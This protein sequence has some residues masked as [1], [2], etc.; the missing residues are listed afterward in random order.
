MR[1]RVKNHRY[2]GT[3]KLKKQQ[4]VGGSDIS[5]RLKEKLKTREE[6]KCAGTCLKS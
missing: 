5:Q 1:I 6:T 2:L 3:Y 4:K